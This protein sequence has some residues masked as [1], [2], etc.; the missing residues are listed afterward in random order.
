MRDQARMSTMNRIIGSA[1]AIVA[2]ESSFCTG[3]AAVGSRPRLP[4]SSPAP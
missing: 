2:S 1:S 4:A 3:A